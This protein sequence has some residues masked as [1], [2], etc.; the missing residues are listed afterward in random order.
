MIDPKIRRLGIG[1]SE[2]GALFGCDG[3]R[4]AF[5]VWA[6]KKGGLPSLPPTD[7][8]LLG[9]ALEPG[10][11]QLYTHVTGREVDYC[12]KTFLHVER[13]YMVYTPDAFCKHDRRGVDAKVVAWDQRRK[14]GPTSDDIPQRIQLQCWWYMA[15]TDYDVW[16]V[17]ALL[18][19]GMPRVYEVIRDVEAERVML[20]RAEEF[21]LRY[22]VGDEVPEMGGTDC[23]S[24]WLQQ[25]FPHHKRP[26]LRLATDA[27]I[28]L[29]D[30][31]AQVRLEQKDLAEQ[32]A[33][34]EN[35]IKLAI[36]EREGLVWF[37]GKFTWRKCKDK[38]V[39]DWESMALGLMNQYVK[40]EATRATL[41]EMYTY[42]KSGSRR[43]WFDSD[44]LHDTSDAA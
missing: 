28:A 25:A 35:Q 19:D 42:T 27:E 43:I 44:L 41:M 18:G 31:Y 20:A 30:Q 36:A 7:R 22:L 1:G 2:V 39:T 37:G 11:L 14:W 26:D 6:E 13:P 16:D 5:S 33:R 38:A 29:L 17:A 24:L 10:V 12:D 32:R 34:L 9:K 40:D 15:A 21:Y 3:D 23:A 4:D 8:M